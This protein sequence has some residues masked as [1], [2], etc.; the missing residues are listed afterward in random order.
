MTKKYRKE[1]A[2]A[3]RI[4]VRIEGQSETYTLKQL[5]KRLHKRFFKIAVWEEKKCAQRDGGNSQE[6]DC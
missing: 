1:S 5:W 6:S 4:D 3:V 2:S